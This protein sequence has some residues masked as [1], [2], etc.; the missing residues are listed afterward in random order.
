M[1]ISL[2]QNIGELLEESKIIN[3]KA[4]YKNTEVDY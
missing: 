1:K 3:W 4:H 2:K